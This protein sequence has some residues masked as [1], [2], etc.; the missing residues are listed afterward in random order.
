[1]QIDWSQAPE[2]ARWWAVDANGQ[3]SWFCVPNVPMSATAWLALP[4][5][6][7]DFGFKGDWKT[8]LVERSPTLLQDDSIAKRFSPDAP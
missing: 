7:P 5:S 2:T 3:A 6:A 8:S 4:V 1:M